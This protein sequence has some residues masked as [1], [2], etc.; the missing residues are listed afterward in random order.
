[1]TRPH[2]RQRRLRRGSSAAVPGARPAA[3]P[4]RRKR[5]CAAGY[6]VDGVPHVRRPASRNGGRRR[7]VL[8]PEESASSDH[9]AILHDLPRVAAAVVRSTGARADAPGRR[10]R[11]NRRRGAH[12]RQRDT[13]RAART[14]GDARHRRADARSA[15]VSVNIRYGN[16]WPSALAQK[17]RCGCRSAQRRVSRHARPR[18][19]QPA[20]AAADGSAAPEVSGSRGN[21]SPPACD[22][23][24][25]QINHLVRLV[26]DLLEV[27]R[28]TRG[29]DRSPA[30]A[31]RSH[32]VVHSAVETSR[33]AFGCGGA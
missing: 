3:T 15:L 27:S 26:N 22:L 4:R 33:P 14:R 28:I 17:K 2:E 24:E 16:I 25:R 7:R 5:C 12:A 32:F 10:F 9:N 23:M 11:A 30:R 31:A 13:S 20:G 19:A 18:A 21:Q 8:L 6:R 1:M 29:I